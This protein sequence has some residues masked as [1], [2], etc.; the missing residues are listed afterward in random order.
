MTSPL[1]FPESYVPVT[2][3]DGGCQVG[4]IIFHFSVKLFTSF[5]SELHMQN[6]IKDV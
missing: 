6:E 1:L 4:P 3:L 5:S 2:V